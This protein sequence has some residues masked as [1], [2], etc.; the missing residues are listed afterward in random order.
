M[1]DFSDRTFIFHKEQTTVY[2][3]TFTRVLPRRR[4]S[5]VCTFCCSEHTG[6]NQSVTGCGS[7]RRQCICY[8]TK[9]HVKSMILI[10]KLNMTSMRNIY[11]KSGKV[12]FVEHHTQFNV[13]VSHRS[14][15]QFED[16]HHAVYMSFR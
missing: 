5:A 6:Y 9:I 12:V 3:Q 10:L 14:Q 16:G 15:I 2:V 7:Q 11:I 1:F 13:D 8:S 4:R